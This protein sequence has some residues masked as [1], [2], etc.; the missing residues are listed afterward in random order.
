MTKRQHHDVVNGL[1]VDLHEP[2]CPGMDAD[3]NWLGDC[4]CSDQHE[5]MPAI[6]WNDEAADRWID[7]LN[8]LS[9]TGIDYY[10]RVALKEI[11][12]N[13]DSE[14]VEG[15]LASADRSDPGSWPRLTLRLANG[16]PLLLLA[17]EIDSV[18]VY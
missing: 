12:P 11:P 1:R 10:V 7:A 4:N 8:G 13:R 18:Y 6:I 2:N 9:L 16:R 3:G 5:G 17:D 14:T 15:Y